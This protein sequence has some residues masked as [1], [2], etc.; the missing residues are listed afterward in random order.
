MVNSWPDWEY[1]PDLIMPVPLHSRRLK[2]RGFNQSAL[3]AAYLGESLGIEVNSK[4]LVRVKNTKP[5]VGL[6]PE[7]R[8]E[9]VRNAFQAQDEIVKN[10]HVLLIDDVLTTG[11]TM[12]AANISLQIAGAKTVSAYCLARAV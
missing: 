7:Q 11:A 8:Q 6:N 3:L 5:Q 4:D 9:N 2:Q 12:L 10:K 1:P